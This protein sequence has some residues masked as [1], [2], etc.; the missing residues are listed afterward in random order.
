MAAALIHRNDEAGVDQFSVERASDI[1]NWLNSL[2]R[3]EEA[4]GFIEKNGYTYDANTG[5]RDTRTVSQHL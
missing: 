4:I 2:P 3:L 1:G 5:F